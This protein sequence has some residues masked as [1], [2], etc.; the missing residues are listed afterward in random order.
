MTAFLF[1]LYC[2]YTT[3]L[4]MPYRMNQSD[5]LTL[6]SLVF[7][8]FCLLIWTSLTNGLSSSCLIPL[9][10]TK[11]LSLSRSQPSVS[12]PKPSSTCEINFSESL[13]FYTPLRTIGL[14]GSLLWYTQKRPSVQCVNCMSMKRSST[15]KPAW[16]STLSAGIPGSLTKSSVAVL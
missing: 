16:I 2:A 8:T 3:T 9:S 13:S 7:T 4:V 11:N 6:P 15:A 1:A 12:L 5:C 14:T 10:L